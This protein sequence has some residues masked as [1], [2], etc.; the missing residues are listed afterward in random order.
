MPLSVVCTALLLLAACGDDDPAPAATPAA[1]IVESDATSD[2]AAGDITLDDTAMGDTA[3]GDASMDDAAEGD[4]AMPD[5]GPSEDVVEP[6]VPT[7]DGAVQAIIQGS[8]GG[9]HGS[10]GSWSAGSY[11]DTQMTAYSGQCD[12]MTKG[13]CFSVRIKD[14]TMP[15]NGSVLQSMMDSGDLETLDAWI[16]GGMPEN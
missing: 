8:C 14:E 13:E 7:W 15:T 16:A 3:M 11:S 1:D 5:A 10:A 12:G 9:C 4:T 6:E 2:A